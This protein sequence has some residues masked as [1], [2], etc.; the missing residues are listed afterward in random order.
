MKLARRIASLAA[1][2][3][4][5]SVIIF[6]AL[7][8]APGDVAR[9]MMGVEADPVA[10]E[11]L[12]AQLGLGG[13]PV[14][15]YFRWIGALLVGDLGIS[16]TY[17][18][19]VAGLIAERLAVSAPLA[20]GA[21]VLSSCIAALGALA[22]VF[23]KRGASGQVIS[24]AAYAGIAIPNFWLAMML[25]LL[26]SVAL[27][28]FPAGGFPGWYQPGAALWSLVLP[29]I[30]LGLPQGAIILRVLRASLLDIEQQDFMR[31]ARAK[32]LSCWQTLVRHGLPNALVPVLPLLGL[33]LAFLLAG[34]V[35]VESVFYLPG[36]GRLVLQAVNQRDLVTVKAVVMLLVTAVVLIS[37]LVDLLAAWLDP[38]LRR[39]QP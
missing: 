28:W 12:R 16:Y 13:N 23:Y 21:F 6:V 11:A 19:P 34:A 39:A 31:T 1:T 18:V 27:G 25:V 32:G 15:R 38:R 7:E 9:F 26:F 22:S 8:I 24:G 29:V 35:I 20:L 10:V 5:A 14:E 33:Q 30:A 2:L 37:F 17:R 4:A 36:L 3:V